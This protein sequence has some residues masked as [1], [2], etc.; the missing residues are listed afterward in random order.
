MPEAR[1]KSCARATLDRTRLYF[2]FAE[3]IREELT[4][5]TGRSVALP[6]ICFAFALLYTGVGLLGCLRQLI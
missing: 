6:R 5:D 1:I 4:I 2:A 3:Q